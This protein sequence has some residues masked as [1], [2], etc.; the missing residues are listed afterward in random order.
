MKRLLLLLVATL[1]MSGSTALVFGQQSWDNSGNNLLNGT[2]NFREILWV[3]DSTASNALLRATSRYGT[4]NFNGDGN[5]VVNTAFEWN[6]DTNL[7]TALTAA[8]Q[9]HLRNL[10]RAVWFPGTGV[11][12]TSCSGSMVWFQTES[13]LAAAQRA[14]V[15]NLCSSPRSHPARKLPPEHSNKT[16]PSRIPI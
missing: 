5:Y 3:T 16:I 9:P 11:P 6:S 14:N 7:V 15:N 8:H 12:P 10:S 4:I 2:Y 13:S 1:L